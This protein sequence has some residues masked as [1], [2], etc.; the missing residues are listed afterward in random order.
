MNYV[1][2][3]ATK[4]PAR[5][6]QKGQ[7]GNPLG[8]PKGSKNKITLM[9]LQLEGELRTQIK[10]DMQDIVAKAI[11]MAKEGD[12]Q[13]IKLL[14]DKCISPARADESEGE[15][16]KGVNVFVG[17]MPDTP[18]PRGNGITIDNGYDNS[19]QVEQE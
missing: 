13:M 3:P 7:S 6:W 5:L 4:M 14:V 15:G 2:K 19:V 1:T 16:V 10:R 18:E 11:T 17:R 12:A 9:K 8:R